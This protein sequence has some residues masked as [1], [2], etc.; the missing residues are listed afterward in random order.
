MVSEAEKVVLGHPWFQRMFVTVLFGSERFLILIFGRN[1]YKQCCDGFFFFHLMT[2]LLCHGFYCLFYFLC[3]FES[4][5]ENVCLACPVLWH[6]TK[7]FRSTRRLTH[8]SAWA[9]W[10]RLI[11][12]R[13]SFHYFQSEQT[14]ESVSICLSVCLS[15]LS[16]KSL[17]CNFI[18]SKCLTPLFSTFYFIYFLYA[19]LFQ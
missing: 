9:E 19:I 17:N 18:L 6:T 14:L 5:R 8:T 3:M 12:L 2:H 10:P 4:T 15:V 1:C 16:H 13:F 11:S 7:T